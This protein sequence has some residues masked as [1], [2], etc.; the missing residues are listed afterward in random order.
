MYI[1]STVCL[2]L[3]FSISSELRIALLVGDQGA[4]NPYY[5]MD[6]GDDSS[7]LV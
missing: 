4:M 7:R 2:M 3:F 6:L 5:V 1:K